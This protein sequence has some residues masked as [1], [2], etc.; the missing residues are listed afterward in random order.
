MGRDGRRIILIGTVPKAAGYDRLCSQKALRFPW[1]TC[2]AIVVPPDPEL[3]LLNER[4]RAFADTR[5]GV[6]YF[7][8]TEQL[9]PLARCSSIDEDGSPRYFDVRHLT[10]AAS[11]QLGLRIVKDT[12]VPEPFVGVAQT[13]I[14]SASPPSLLPRRRSEKRAAYSPARRGASQ[15]RTR[16]RRHGLDPIQ[17]TISLR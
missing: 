17:W 7:D 8:A 14:S 6:E 10:M 5:K 16:A 9:C 15:R 1:L 12:G 4:L 13:P 3:L 11:E 2:Q